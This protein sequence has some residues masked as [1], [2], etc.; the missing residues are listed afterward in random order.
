MFS[1]LQSRTGSPEFVLGGAIL[2]TVFPSLWNE[3]LGCSCATIN[4]VKPLCMVHVQVMYWIRG[5]DMPERGVS[6]PDATS[7]T[8]SSSLKS[9]WKSYIHT[10]PKQ[11]DDTF[12]SLSVRVFS[13][14]CCLVSHVE[15]LHSKLWWYYGPFFCHALCMKVESKSKSPVCWLI[16]H[17]CRKSQIFYTERISDSKIISRSSPLWEL[18]KGK[19]TAGTV[20]RTALHM[21]TIYVLSKK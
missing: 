5:K 12:I 15:N 4:L 8:V 18:S 21:V 3:D 19:K 9:V 10:C 13:T 17:S 2:G 14:H 16:S 6:G 7:D 1:H 11:P 20:K